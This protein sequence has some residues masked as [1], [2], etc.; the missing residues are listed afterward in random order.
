MTVHEN[1]GATVVAP[2]GDV[3]LHTASQLRLELLDQIEAGPTELVVDLAGVTFLDSE[4]LG[5]L[6]GA[7]HRQAQ[8]GGRLVL[9]NAGPDLVAVF[10]TTGLDRVFDF[11]NPADALAS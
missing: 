2:S 4:G 5:V 11:A 6:E 9:A 3:D 1:A 7:R 8:A 10:R